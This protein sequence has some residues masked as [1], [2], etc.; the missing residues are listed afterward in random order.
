[1][2]TRRNLLRAASLA[3]VPAL[4]GCDGND[5]YARL[6]NET[7][8]LPAAPPEAMQLRREL[9]R[10]ATL[11]PSSHNT[12]CWRFR[13]GER[14]ID[15]LPDLARRCPAV[16]PDDHHL[17]VS[18]GCAAENLVQ[19]AL[20]HGW[21]AQATAAAGGGVAITLEATTARSTPLYGAVAQR[22]STRGEYDGRP[23]STPELGLLEQAGSGQGVRVLMI[24]GRAAM[25]QLLALV[26]AGNTAQMRDA[27]FV[28]ELKDWIRF[29]PGEAARSG[30]GLYTACT[31]NPTVPRWLGSPLF[32]L[33][34]TADG[35]NDK[36]SRQIRSSAGLAVFVSD[37]DDPAH[38]IETGRC[39]ERFALQ[40]TAL[41]IRT[42]YLNQPVEVAA[43]RPQL[44][45][46]LGIGTR[47]PDLVVRFGRGPR[48]PVSLRRPL[49]AVIDTL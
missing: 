28:A 8:R 10:C 5:A 48:L 46:L 9:V 31:G 49:A 35:E 38:W 22:Q 17:H 18:L 30:D 20:H 1:M 45:A 33:F 16:D 40:A 34:F 29:S 37:G 4:A 12:Q 36:Y 43:L 23:L 13:L 42:A 11:A 21:H 39:V 24:T 32:D 47:R 27:A 7:W 15:I 25:E 14:G 19:A 6:A 26:V 3:A 44:A 41:D 2:P